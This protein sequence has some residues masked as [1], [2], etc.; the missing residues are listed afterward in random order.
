MSAKPSEPIVVQLSL[1]EAELVHEALEVANQELV[2]GPA[3]DTA[4]RA[5]MRQLLGDE[6]A[7]RKS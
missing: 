3:A 7:K 4:K 5:Q 2:G 1:R 6:I